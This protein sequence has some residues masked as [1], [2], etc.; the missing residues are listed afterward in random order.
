[1][2]FSLEINGLEDHSLCNFIN[3]SNVISS[4]ISKGEEDNRF[5]SNPLL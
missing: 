3:L 4:K 5:R 2:S 1:M